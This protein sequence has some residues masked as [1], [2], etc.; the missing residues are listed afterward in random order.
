[1]HKSISTR[2]LLGVLALLASFSLWL[3]ASDVLRLVVDCDPVLLGRYSLER[4]SRLLIATALLWLLAG[5]LFSRR[6]FDRELAFQIIAVTG[7]SLLGLLLVAVL[8]PMIIPARYEVEPF[9]SSQFHKTVVAQSAGEAG[10]ALQ[11]RVVRRKPGLNLSFTHDDVQLAA[12]SHPE[13][14]AGYPRITGK[15]TTDSRG[16]RNRHALDHADVVAVGDSFTEGDRV[17]DEDTWPEVLARNSQLSVYNL[18]VSGLAPQ[19]YLNNLVTYGLDLKPRIVIVMF[20]EGNDFVTRKHAYRLH[21]Q[22]LLHNSPLGSALRSLLIS[23]FGGMKPDIPPRSTNP[24]LSWVPVG[25]HA[26]GAVRYYSFDPGF[27]NKLLRT[28][29]E[30]IRSS[31]WIDNAR[32]VGE[33]HKLAQE[34]NIRFILAYAPI[35]ARVVLP[36]I[37]DQLTDEVLHGFLSTV[38]HKLPSVA[39]FK[40]NVYSQLDT[41]E[42]ALREFCLAEGIEFVSMTSMLRE[43]VARGEQ[44]YFSYDGHWSPSGQRAVGTALA[45]HLQLHRTALSRK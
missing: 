16:F 31:D 34:N 38:N 22:G 35:N 1:M 39:G 10:K 45:Q 8:S 23:T 18:G 29:Q 28:R 19:E 17:S 14:L 33:M 20:Y 24:A 43:R 3:P 13:G 11:G 9:N 42:N 36:L 27:L 4:F 25:I 44:V 5:L 21:E 41:K 2:R 37:R 32:T 7:S 12:C 26:G 40:D 30:F 15:M 6:R